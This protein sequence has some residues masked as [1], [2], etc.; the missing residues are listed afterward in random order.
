MIIIMTKNDIF[1]VCVTCGEQLAHDAFKVAQSL[2]PAFISCWIGQ[3]RMLP[4]SCII[5]VIGQE[6]VLPLRP[7]T[8]YTWLSLIS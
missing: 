5:S 8:V 3:V 2:D 6:N 7:V 4:V 1:D